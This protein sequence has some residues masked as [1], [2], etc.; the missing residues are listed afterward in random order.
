[1]PRKRTDDSTLSTLP[2]R[3]RRV[4]WRFCGGYED[5]WEKPVITVKKAGFSSPEN[6]GSNLLPLQAT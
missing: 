5:R 1:L 2:E 4:P 3:I 6:K